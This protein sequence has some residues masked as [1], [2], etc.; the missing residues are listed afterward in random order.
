V[1]TTQLTPRP[2]ATL[3]ASTVSITLAALPVFLVGALAVFIR[4]ELGFGEAQ[5]GITASLY[6]LTSALSSAPGGRVTE[7]LGARRGIALAAVGTTVSMLGIA[8]ANGWIMLTAFMM[9][10]GAVNGIALPA[11]NLALARG[12]P[13]RRQGIAFGLKQSAGPFAALLAGASVP[14]LGLT[15]GWRWAFVTAAILAGPLVMLWLGTRAPAAPAERRSGDVAT[16]PLLV[17]ATAAG[18][19]VIGGSSLGSF[20]VESAVASGIDAGTAGTLLAIGS[21]IGIAGRLSIGWLGDI[22]P[23]THVPL[24]T[25]LLGIG[26]ISFIGLGRTASPTPLLVVTVIAFLTGWGWPALYNFAVVV[27]SPGAPAIASGITATGIYTGG[28]FG[29]VA[30]GMIVE[31]SSYG[32]AWL[33]VGISLAISAALMHV[34]GRMLERSVTPGR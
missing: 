24:L 28:V 4:D 18:F 3:A 12:V 1:T 7:R 22:Y 33:M 11:S 14:L 9:L 20:Y 5:L 13:L 30:F 31:R 8:M 6:Y 10:A 23:N 26:A 32:S 34:G 21:I 15:V 27:R 29:P 17:L 25:G 2:I 19:A 16:R